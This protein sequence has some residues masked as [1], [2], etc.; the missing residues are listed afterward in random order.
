MT[1]KV[2]QRMVKINTTWSYHPAPIK[3]G[4]NFSSKGLA[5]LCFHQCFLESDWIYPKGPQIPRPWKP[6][7]EAGSADASA[8]CKKLCTAWGSNWEPQNRL[9][10]GT[11]RSIQAS[12]YAATKDTFL[13]ASKFRPI[14]LSPCFIKPLE[15]PINFQP[16]MPLF[17]CKILRFQQEK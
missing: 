3:I 11:P 16:E 2:Q 12:Y 9:V 1:P 4:K 7:T 6:A 15:K 13:L 10:G 5:W 8:A 14:F 17:F